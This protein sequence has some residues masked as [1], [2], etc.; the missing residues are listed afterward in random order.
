MGRRKNDRFLSWQAP[1]EHIEEATH[2]RA[3]DEGACQNER[4]H[5]IFKL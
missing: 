3:E 2:Y 1:D 4:S 5:L